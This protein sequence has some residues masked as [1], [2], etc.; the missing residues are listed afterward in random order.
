MIFNN[1]PIK[2]FILID[3]D[4]KLPCWKFSKRLSLRKDTADNVCGRMIVENMWE[5][6]LY[7][8]IQED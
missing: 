4:V 2:C 3:P 6:Q 8:G 7:Q 1:F 5:E